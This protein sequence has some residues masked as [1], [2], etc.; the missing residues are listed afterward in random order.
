MKSLFVARLFACVSANVILASSVLAAE[1][2]SVQRHIPVEKILEFS[3]SNLKESLEKTAQKNERLAFENET[4]RENIQD[5]QRKHNALI[6][7]KS[8]LLG[9]P[10]SMEETKSRVWPARD[11]DIQERAQRIHER[12]ASFRRDI[13]RLQD[14]NQIL[15]DQLDKKRYQAK[16]G[17]M[18]EKAESGRRNLARLEKNIKVLKKRNKTPLRTIEALEKEKRSLERRINMLEIESGRSP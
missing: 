6:A 18:E 15:S 2:G 10:I 3:L 9:E 16:R 11:I 4:L 8:E 5:L 1:R 13:L 12:I 14:Q 17:L 7:R